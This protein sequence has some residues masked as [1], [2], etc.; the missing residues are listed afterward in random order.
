M[1]RENRLPGDTGARRTIWTIVLG[2]LIVLV[3]YN[4]YSGVAVRKIGI[5]GMFEVEFGDQPTRSIA[6]TEKIDQMSSAELKERQARLEE[7]LREMET[8]RETP[9]PQPLPETASFYG[10]WQSTQGISYIINQ[11]GTYITIQEISPIYG[12]TAVGQGTVYGRE[13]N[14][15]YYTAAGTTGRA[16]LKLSGD[17]RQLQGG[18]TDLNTGASMPLTLFR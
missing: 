4:I 9:A 6:G 16:Q 2:L 12:V 15:S 7:K 14:V 13:I 3:G 17:G 5:P 8:R 10:T 11:N 1:P 18:F